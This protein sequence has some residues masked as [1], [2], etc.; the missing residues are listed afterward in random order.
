LAKEAHRIICGLVNEKPPCFC[1]LLI[2]VT[3]LAFIGALIF[4]KKLIITS[5]HQVYS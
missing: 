2:G 5:A 4:A 1:G 3:L